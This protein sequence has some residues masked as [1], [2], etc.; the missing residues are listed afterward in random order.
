MNTWQLQHL[1]EVFSAHGTRSRTV[2]PVT[3]ALCKALGAGPAPAV[4]DL[5]HRYYRIISNEEP[6]VPL[7]LAGLHHLA[8]SGGAPA[9]ATFFPSCGGS[10]QA[11]SD[12]QA[13]A[14]A[15]QAAV[16]EGREALLDYLLSYELQPHVAERSAAVALG[17]MAVAAQF[18][19]GVTLVEMGCSGGLNLLFDRYAYR[20][21]GTVVGESPLVLPVEGQ[22]PV[23]PLPAVTGR[24]G[25]DPAPRN[26]ADEAD[27]LLLESFFAPD[28]AEAIAHL[29]T[30]A[31]LMAQQGAPDIRTGTAEDDLLPLLEEA[32]AAMPEGNTLLLVA[33]FVW[34]YLSDLQKEQAVWAIQ[35]QAARLTAHK[36]MAW[37]QLEPAPGGVAELKLHTFDWTDQ[38]N[39]TVRRLAETD[40]FCRHFRWVE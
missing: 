32:Y 34:P 5:L 37:L 3:E 19:G 10:F 23:R 11:D 30:A 6:N 24:Y 21:E 9:L 31:G 17:A 40:P 35:R 33:T 20:F 2:S 13:L 39:R 1:R 4:T 14:T 8:L 22:V 28:A 7:L 16:A 25:L 18:G 26:P 15:A 29:R 36:P 27:R 12:D 38:E